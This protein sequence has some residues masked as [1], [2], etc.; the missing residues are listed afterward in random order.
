MGGH[1]RLCFFALRFSPFLFCR[2]FHPFVQFFL[3]AELF[4]PV[5][6][7]FE[8]KRR[9]WAGGRLGSLFDTLAVGAEQGRVPGVAID[10]PSATASGGALQAMIARYDPEVWVNALNINDS[11]QAVPIE[12]ALEVALDVLPDLIFEALTSG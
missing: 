1:A 11:R 10:R 9:R 12:S 7:V 3:P 4:E 2:Y 5:F 6:D 8:Q